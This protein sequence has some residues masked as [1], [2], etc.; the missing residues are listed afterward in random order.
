VETTVG[1]GG[2]AVA[3]DSGEGGGCGAGDGGADGELVLGL[4]VEELEAERGSAV[5]VCCTREDP[6][7]PQTWGEHLGG[8]LDYPPRPREVGDGLGERCAQQPDAAVSGP[9]DPVPLIL[10]RRES[11][12]GL[13][14][15]LHPDAEGPAALIQLPQWH[16]AGYGRV[17]IAGQQDRLGLGAGTGPRRG[18]PLR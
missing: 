5:Q 3:D 17:V 12:P 11:V 13:R 14:G 9:G 16:P 6:S 10:R 2:L 7:S 15:D 8:G 1:F 4:A 18:R